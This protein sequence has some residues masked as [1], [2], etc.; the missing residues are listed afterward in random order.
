LA[1]S[2]GE[3]HGENGG[4][5]NEFLQWLSS[6]EGQQPVKASD[7]IRAAL[8]DVRL[9][10]GRRLF[11]WPEGILRTFD[12]SVTHLQ[13]HPQV[14]SE[15]LV[16]LLLDWM[17]DPERLHE[18]A[19]QEASEEPVAGLERVLGGWIEELERQRASAES[20]G[21]GDPQT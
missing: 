1:G 16:N 12:E 11:V 9:D 15:E 4:E 7:S 2:N 3:S 13:Q 19:S 18:S 8:Q 6:E 10:A 14:A 17:E 5:G 21:G 20:T